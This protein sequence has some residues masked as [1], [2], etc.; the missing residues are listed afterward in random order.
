LDN[1]VAEAAHAIA[2]VGDVHGHLGKLT[3][4]LR[5]ELLIDDDHAWAGD[6]TV[7]WFTGDYCD[8]G[9][10]GVGVI[11]LIMRLQVE[12][13]ATGGKVG[14]LLG[15]HEAVLLAAKR[16][17]DQTANEFDGYSFRDIWLMNGGNPRDIDSLTSGQLSW[18]RS[19][20]AM[21][22]EQDRLLMHPDS[23]IY[24]R[25]GKTIADVNRAVARILESDDV[26]A[27]DRFLRE[28]AQRRSFLDSKPLGG[29]LARNM[30]R[31]FGGRQIVHGHTPIPYL[32]GIDA[33]RIVGP[34]IYS[35]G[36]CVNVDGGMY[37]GG[38]GFVYRLPPRDQVPPIESRGL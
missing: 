36:R 14:A 17:G 38:T 13:R 21:A 6:D 34:L 8:R 22:L 35:N 4:L 7:L 12:A 37:L 33:S 16:F 1:N 18:L 31:R 29:A 23:L 5:A 25:M 15:N 11:D 26:T 28:A 24:K 32:T 30:L 10:D 9:P 19:L 3:R 20:P 27:W 2:I